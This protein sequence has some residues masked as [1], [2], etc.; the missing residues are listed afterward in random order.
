[1]IRY[2]RILE[3]GKIGSMM[4]KNR[5]I[6]PAMSTR[7]CGEDGEATEQFIA[8]HETRARGGWAMMITEDYVIDKGVGMKKRIAGIVA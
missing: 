1:M 8:Y 2:R 6:V 4:L 3:P 7:F 5:L